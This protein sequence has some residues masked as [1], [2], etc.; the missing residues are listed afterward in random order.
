M[1]KSVEDYTV[2]DLIKKYKYIIGN[3]I[4]EVA[5]FILPPKKVALITK[6]RMKQ[7][8]VKPFSKQYK[9]LINELGKAKYQT[10]EEH[11]KSNNK[12][13]NS[14]KHKRIVLTE[15]YIKFS[16]RME[17][18]QELIDLKQ[19]MIGKEREYIFFDTFRDDIPEYQI[20]TKGKNETLEGIE[21]EELKKLIN[22]SFE[23]VQ[24]PE[25]LMAMMKDIYPKEVSS[26]ILRKVMFDLLREKNIVLEGQSNIEKILAEYGKEYKEGVIAFFK[27]NLQFLNKSKILLNFADIVMSEIEDIKNNE[28]ENIELQDITIDVKETIIKNDIQILREIYNRLTLEDDV[29]FRIIYRDEEIVNVSREKIEEFLGR[30]TDSEYLTEEEICKM[31]DAIA[32]GEFINNKEKIKIANID[33]QDL[34][35]LGKNY[36]VKK[37]KEAD[38]EK[39]KMLS[40]AVELA[41]YLNAE[42]LT[43]NKKLLNLYLNGEIHLDIIKKIDM[44]EI[45]PEEYNQ[46]FKMI[47]D[48]ILYFIS[49]EE[50]QKE[51]QK[52]SRLAKLYKHLETEG[53]TDAD[54]LVA[55]L[56][57]A[58]GEEY[59]PDIMSDLYELGIATFET[60]IDWVGIPVLKELCKREK[61]PPAKVSELY[62][63]KV[64]EDLDIIAEIIN[65][66]PNVMQRI[67]L[68][69]SI[70]PEDK[71]NRDELLK[72]CLTVEGNSREKSDD[73]VEKKKK[74]G[75]TDYTKNV[76]DSFDRMTLMKLIDNEYYFEEPTLDGH[77]IIHLPNFQE[78]IVEKMFNRKKESEYGAATYILSEEYFK[79]NRSIIIQEG[80]VYRREFIKNIN[81]RDVEKINHFIE[82]W[83]RKIKEHFGI[84]EESRWTE[85][86]LQKIEEIILKTMESKKELGEDK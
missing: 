51:D 82:T 18:E 66:S 53:K 3:E 43:T 6:E 22:R 46:K 68:I 48:R 1:N 8:N 40:C 2:L 17:S 9:D 28:F 42:G 56:I 11:L 14:E 62:E 31:H 67:M 74:G 33:I 23:S 13:N 86:E 80:K 81:S 77:I 72:R 54:D 20:I 58:Y 16:Y 32:N 75:T 39:T 47:Y 70:F 60:C 44:P 7:E 84:K 83:G 45:T 61:L 52:L 38:E 12:L 64:I 26:I 19:L 5:S 65:V 76:I 73:S 35:N 71:L 79:K 55:R 29:T 30:C 25:E 69:G 15:I 59:G 41:K 49:E 50:K 34:I 85:E 10:V 63:N 57:T 78:V 27:R 37:D 21:D 36:E 4:E 24:R